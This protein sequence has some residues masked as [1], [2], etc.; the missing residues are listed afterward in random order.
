[1]S[2]DNLHA[3]W[4]EIKARAS[5][6]ITLL[7]MWWPREDNVLPDTPAPF[8]YFELIVDRAG[9]PASFGGGRGRNMY[10][11][12]AELNGFVFVPTGYGVEAEADLSEHV[13]A[14]FRSYRSDAISCF[15]A[16]AMPV[17]E[18]SSLSPPGLNS[19]ADQYECSVVSVN[20]FF[21]SIG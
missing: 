8:V 7:P 16:T 20:L 6:Q 12:P 18:G 4:T 10:R 9:P 13:A 1:M 5:S 2:A 17:G 15:D 11:Y 3:V 19:A 21:D 14:A